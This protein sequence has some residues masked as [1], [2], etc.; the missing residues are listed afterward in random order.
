MKVKNKFNKRKGTFI[1]SA[2]FMFIIFFIFC[3][4]SWDTSRLLYFKVYNQ[5]LASAVAIS[6]V[7]ESG[8]YYSDSTGSKTKGF[9]V[10]N[11]HFPNR[12]YPKG[13]TGTP[14]DDP[15]FIRSLLIKNPVQSGDYRIIKVDLNNNYQDYNRYVTGSNGVH[16]EAR[17]TSTIEV[18]MFLSSLGSLA[19]AAGPSTKRI[20]NV[21]TAIPL[22]TATGQPV[23]D[24]NSVSDGNYHYYPD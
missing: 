5:N 19:G 16:G 6:V 7:N 15:S 3:I 22:Y 20:T 24:W 1:L 8:Y 4:F 11:H 9:L 18:D 12:K 14:A 2:L 10:T 13:F 23:I 21:A 17:V